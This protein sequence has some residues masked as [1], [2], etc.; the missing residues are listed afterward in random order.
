MQSSTMREGPQVAGSD[1]YRGRCIIVH[2][3]KNCLRSKLSKGHC[4]ADPRRLLQNFNVSSWLRLGTTE[5]NWNL[6]PGGSRL[7]EWLLYSLSGGKR[8]GDICFSL[9]RNCP[10]SKC[11]K[12]TADNKTS[13]APATILKEE[14][15]C[16]FL[17]SS[18]IL[19]VNAH[20]WG[21]LDWR[22]Y[23]FNECRATFIFSWPFAVR[24][25][26]G[27]VNSIVR[28]RQWRWPFFIPQ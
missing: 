18:L 10:P 9:C 11:L 12:E 27:E 26:Y 19:W 2:P 20:A 25:I 24:H 7:T 6:N 17:R 5:Q 15:I 23:G 21:K 8:K 13:T 14:S 28:A 1:G 3:F 4:R 22:G 16:P